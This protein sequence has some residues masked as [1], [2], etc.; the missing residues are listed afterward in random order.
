M[1]TKEYI[2]KN[3]KKNEKMPTEWE[4]EEELTEEGYTLYRVTMPEGFEKDLIIISGNK[5]FDLTNFGVMNDKVDIFM[6]VR[7]FDRERYLADLGKNLLFAKNGQFLERFKESLETE[8]MSKPWVITAFVILC[9]KYFGIQFRNAEIDRVSSVAPEKRT[10]VFSKED[11]EAHR[12][13][14]MMKLVRKLDEKQTALMCEIAA[15][16]EF[17]R[18]TTEESRMDYL[19]SYA[20]ENVDNGKFELLCGFDGDDPREM[21]E[22][23]GDRAWKMVLENKKKEVNA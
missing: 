13:E 18:C 22:I 16:P 17:Q 14:L 4:L 15:D 12:D 10:P 8:E 6:D 3:S 11:L 5:T 19:A 9:G 2:Y 7:Y 23:F 1:S 21:L 20:A